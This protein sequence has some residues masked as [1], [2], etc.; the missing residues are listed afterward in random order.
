METIYY[1]K[2]IRRRRRRRPLLAIIAFWIIFF[3]LIGALTWGLKTYFLSERT[4]GIA[5]PTPTPTPYVMPTSTPTPETPSRLGEVVENALEGSHGSYGIVI[6][7]FKT[8][9]SYTY[10]D[11]IRYESASLYKLWVMA[12]VEQQI[13]NGSL[14]ESD[15]LSESVATLNKKFDIASD[16]AELTDGTISTTVGDALYQMITISDNYSALILTEKI[17]LSSLSS[18]LQSNGFNQ[19]AVGT[20]DSLPTTTAHDVALFLEKLYKRQLTDDEYS[21][22]MLDLL[23]QQRL[24]SKLPLYLPLAVQVAHKTGEIDNFSH[25]AGIVNAPSGDYI[26][27]VMSQTDNPQEANERI[28]E[29]SKAVYNYFEGK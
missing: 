13:K 11:T 23:K 16:E 8:G 12:V 29:V 25:D 18:F 14:H 4:L 21:S 9:E 24:N 26:I 10:N 7:N 15:A 20:G 28:A 2:Q 22:K 6:K 19:S 17:G 3:S 27:V 1:S 5:A